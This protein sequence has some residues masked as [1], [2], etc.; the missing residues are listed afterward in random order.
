MKAKERARNHPQ[1]LGGT[2]PDHDKNWGLR[3][4]RVVVRVVLQA[5]PNGRAAPT[6]RLTLVALSLLLSAFTYACSSSGGGGSSNPTDEVSDI[7]SRFVACGTADG[8]T[9]AT[10]TQSSCESDFDGWVPPSGCQSAIDS[11]S[12]GTINGGSGGDAL[13][14]CFPSCTG[15]GGTSCSGDDISQCAGDTEAGA[16]TGEAITRTCASVCTEQGQ[17][18]AGVC[19]ASYQGMSSPTGEDTCW[20]Q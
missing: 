6:R 10:F 1:N 16:T 11:A 3:L 12:C 8:T 4:H 2:P 14:T 5:S 20:C 9:G 18:Y 17:T 15:V 7:C 19:G 13:S